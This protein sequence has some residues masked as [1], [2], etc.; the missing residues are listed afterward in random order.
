MIKER[1][2]IQ[3]FRG[4]QCIDDYQQA[5][6]LAKEMIE[7]VKQDMW[8]ND[9]WWAR[10]IDNHKSLSRL[11]WLRGNYCWQQSQWLHLV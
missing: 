4:Y 11:V 7:G 6:A 2:T 3:T 8:C 5:F 10:I 9:Y 1:Y